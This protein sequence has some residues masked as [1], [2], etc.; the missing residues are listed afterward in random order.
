MSSRLRDLYPI[1]TSFYTAER[2]RDRPRGSD[3]TSVS[4][5]N[6]TLYLLGC[7]GYCNRKVLSAPQNQMELLN[8][9]TIV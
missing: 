7:N 6:P 2:G 8:I 5:N 9:G 3:V 4:K 1:T